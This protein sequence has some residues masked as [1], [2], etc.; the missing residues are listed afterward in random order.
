MKNCQISYYLALLLF[1]SAN[2]YD[3]LHP[4]LIS[5]N[6]KSLETRLLLF[7]SCLKN[8]MSFIAQHLG[9]ALV[10]MPIPRI[11]A[12]ITKKNILQLFVHSNISGDGL[13]INKRKS[14]GKDIEEI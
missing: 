2:I 10:S 13:F 1:C 14:S 3:F 4:S 8:L 7:S 6:Q 9:E 11:V 12:L 5:K